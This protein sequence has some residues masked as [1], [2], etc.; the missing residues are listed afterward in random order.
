MLPYLFLLL[1]QKPARAKTQP[2][3]VEML[4]AKQ[5]QLLKRGDEGAEAD[6]EEAQDYYWSDA[7]ADTSLCA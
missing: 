5:Q 1:L 7:E 6:D 3:V 2:T 4:N